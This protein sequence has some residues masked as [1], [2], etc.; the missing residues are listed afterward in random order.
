MASLSNI[1]VDTTFILSAHD[2]KIQFHLQHVRTFALGE[3]EHMSS[4]F[5]FDRNLY[6][7]MDV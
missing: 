2:M 1:E 6:H 5:Q 4:S 3:L 7:A